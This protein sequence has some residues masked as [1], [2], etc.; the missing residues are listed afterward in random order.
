MSK[1]NQM[2]AKKK[3]YSTS[4]LFETTNAN[5]GSPHATD[6]NFFQSRPST[7]ESVA[8]NR[9]TSQQQMNTKKPQEEIVKKIVKQPVPVR[10]RNELQGYYINRM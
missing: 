8:S 10:G 3:N 6:S 1:M 5:K 7:S 9:Y 2:K 4:N